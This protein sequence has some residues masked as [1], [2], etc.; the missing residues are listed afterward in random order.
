VHAVWI[1]KPVTSPFGERERGVLMKYLQS[2]CHFDGSL[3]GC[4]SKS[5]GK[6]KIKHRNP[7][8]VFTHWIWKFHYFSGVVVTTAAAHTQERNV[9]MN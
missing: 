1:L 3:A 7:L 2:F 9:I 6:S 4:K 8:A 5:G